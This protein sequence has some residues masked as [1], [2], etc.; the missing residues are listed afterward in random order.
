M[1]CYTSRQLKLN[2]KIDKLNWIK[3][4]LMPRI[5]L[6][7][8]SVFKC[9][10][11]LFFSNISSN[12]S[13]NI[14]MLRD[15]LDFFNHQKYLTCRKRIEDRG[16]IPNIAPRIALR[17]VVMCRWGHSKIKTVVFKY[18][19]WLG[20]MRTSFNSIPSRNKATK[21]LEGKTSK[22]QK[23]IRRWTLHVPLLLVMCLCLNSLL[24]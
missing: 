19:L 14:S 7:L 20:M 16:H 12:S 17:R 1:V 18:D 8:M 6:L 5:E 10:L 3:N 2:Y 24:N 4:F 22:S 13:N 9:I 15:N 23:P 11:I 21:Q